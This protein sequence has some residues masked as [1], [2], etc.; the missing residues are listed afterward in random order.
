[1]RLYATI[2]LVLLG[3]LVVPLTM[4]TNACTTSQPAPRTAS[5]SQPVI[6]PFEQADK[7]VFVQVQLEH[8]R[9][10]WFVLD[11]A[12]SRML[13]EQKVAAA[14]GLK[15]EGT[16][17][18]GGA[19][20]GRVPINLIH[21]LSIQL[22]GLKSTHYEFA[23]IDLSGVAAS[24]GRPID[25]I[26]GYEFLSRFIVTIDYAKHELVLNE[27][28]SVVSPPGTPMPIE[29]V[30]H[31][32]FIK[33]TVKVKGIEP[34]SD[35]F[36]IDSGSNDAVDHPAV[37]RAKGEVRQTTTGNG[38]GQ[39]VVGYIGTAE[40]FELGSFSLKDLPLVCCG[41]TEET[42]KLIG[43]DVLSRF[44]VTFDYPHARIFLAARPVATSKER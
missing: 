25:G 1:M 31:W 20:A 30:K 2:L 26:L 11:S 18:V 41:G 43:G 12:S 27:P 16:A 21:D 32:P 7:L 37:K 22:G 40:T 13:V 24:I 9:P 3:C 39:P 34:I 5:N 35:S 6:V 17:S 8:S 33:A 23:A 36:L 19:G 28:Q 44:I 15:V 42:S 29:L 38:L 4:L 10:L 14:L